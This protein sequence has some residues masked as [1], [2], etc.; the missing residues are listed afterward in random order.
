ME[1]TKTKDSFIPVADC[2]MCGLKDTP[3]SQEHRIYK[4]KVTGKELDLWFISCPGCGWLA[5]MD[6]ESMKHIKGYISIKDLEALGY[7]KGA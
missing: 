2:P 4:H 7:T 3:L 1:L 5:N 6:K